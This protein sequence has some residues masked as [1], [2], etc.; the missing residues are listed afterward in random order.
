MNLSPIQQELIGLLIQKG[1]IR[2]TSQVGYALWPDRDMQSQGAAAAAGNIIYR[3]LQK[4]YIA[5]TIIDN[6]PSYSVTELGIAAL[7]EDRLAAIDTRQL[8][9]F[10]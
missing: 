7:E 4:G 10:E 8:S 5:N 2:G 9:I 1:T 6:L 3:L